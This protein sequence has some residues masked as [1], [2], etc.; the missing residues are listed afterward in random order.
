MQNEITFVISPLLAVKIGR[1]P[2]LAIMTFHF[3]LYND[4]LL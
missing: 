2:N 4:L 1:S 3:G